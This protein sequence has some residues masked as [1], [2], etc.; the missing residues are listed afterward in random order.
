MYIPVCVQGYV[1]YVHPLPSVFLFTKER[2]SGE[3]T[4]FADTHKMLM[5]YAYFS[6]LVF[7]KYIFILINPYDYVTTYST[8]YYL[9]QKIILSILLGIADPVIL[10]GLNSRLWLDYSCTRTGM[11]WVRTCSTCTQCTYTYIY[12]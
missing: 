8:P 2:P 4:F 5:W 9:H 10:F 1:D 11:Y 3:T 12:I 6:I 7:F